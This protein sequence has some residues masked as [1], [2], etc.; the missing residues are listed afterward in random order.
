VALIHM[1]EAI[2]AVGVTIAAGIAEPRDVSI[3]KLTVEANGLA[4]PRRPSL[5]KARG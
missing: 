5:R 3:E 2:P 4:V 1:S